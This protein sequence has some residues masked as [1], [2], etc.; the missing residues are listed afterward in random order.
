MTERREDEER[1]LDRIV[2]NITEMLTEQDADVY[3]SRVI[4]EFKR[5]SNL[6][7][8]DDPDARGVSDGLCG[9]TMVVYLRIEEER[10]E[11]CTFETDGCGATVACGSMLTR[12]ASG[13]PLESASGIDSEELLSALGGLPEDHRHCA[14]LAVIALRNA[15]RDFRRRQAGEGT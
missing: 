5:P 15:I 4:R 8:M 1:E 6:E 13:M 9:D 10:I 2:A 3:S 14:T 12:I 11:R 7:H